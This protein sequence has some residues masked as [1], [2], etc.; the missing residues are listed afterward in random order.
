[1]G[2]QLLDKGEKVKAVYS[3]R[4][5]PL[6]TVAAEVNHN[7]HKNT[8]TQLIFGHAPISPVPSFLPT[9]CICLCMFGQNIED[10]CGCQ[11]SASPF[12]QWLSQSPRT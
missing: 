8:D 9:R 2:I 1:M 6:T 12:S 11:V 4:L 3:Q 10:C 5:N 7:I